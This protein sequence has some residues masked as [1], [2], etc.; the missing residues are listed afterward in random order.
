MRVR[1]LLSATCGRYQHVTCGHTNEEAELE[2]KLKLEKRSVGLVS[3][4]SDSSPED[5]RY[6]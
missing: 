1:H 2:E 6:L 4:A 3:V 5:T